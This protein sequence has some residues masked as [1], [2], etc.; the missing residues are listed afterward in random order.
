[1]YKKINILLLIYIISCLY[2]KFI[3]HYIILLISIKTYNN[4]LIFL[5][6]LIQL[7]NFSLLFELENK[8]IEE[9]NIIQDKYIK[10]ISN[11][12]SYI[13]KKQEELNNLTLKQKIE[14][15]KFSR[16]CNNL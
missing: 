6:I 14:K 2:N 15:Q 13:C 5:I 8:K 3:Y 1:M 7:D 4:L 10:I 12:L 9:T 16:S 11:Q